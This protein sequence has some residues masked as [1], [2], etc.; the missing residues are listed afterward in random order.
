MADSDT[1]ASSGPVVCVRQLSAS[2]SVVTVPRDSGE[3]GLGRPRRRI[4]TTVCAVGGGG[5]LSAAVVLAAAAAAAA[6]VAGAA[7]RSGRAGSGVRRK[8]RRIMC[9]G[10]PLAG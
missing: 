3:S 9:P 8:G 5:S 1:A 6:L 4:S 10:P 2:S 7:M